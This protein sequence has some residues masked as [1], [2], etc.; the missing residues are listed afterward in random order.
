MNHLAHCFLSGDDPDCLF[1]NFIGDYVKGNDWQAYPVRVQQGLLLHRRIDSFTDGHPSVHACTQLL[2][3]H[4]GRV[5]GP[6][7]DILF[8]HLLTLHWAQF[9]PNESLDN[10]SV[11]CYEAIKARSAELPLPLQEVFPR[12][13]ARDFLRGYGQRE[14]LDFVFG[15][16]APRL[17]VPINVSAMLD[18]FFEERPAFEAHFLVFLPELMETVRL[19]N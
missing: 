9:N 6:V 8:D 14:E 10:F 2:R 7:C 1:G 19:V 16:F 17:P 11:R 15:K 12:M 18:F 5:S 13:V 3:P 4:A